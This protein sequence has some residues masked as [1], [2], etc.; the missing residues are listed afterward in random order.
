MLLRYGSNRIEQPSPDDVAQHLGKMQ[1]LDTLVLE[2]SPETFLQVLYAQDSY[3]IEYRQS[4]AKN[5]MK[6]SKPANQ[7]EVLRVFGDFMEQ[8]QDGPPQ[9]PPGTTW[10]DSSTAAPNKFKALQNYVTR[11]II[12]ADLRAEDRMLQGGNTPSL[13]IID[14]TKAGLFGR[15]WLLLIQAMLVVILIGTFIALTYLLIT[16]YGT[17]PIGWFIVILLIDIWAFFAFITVQ[18]ALRWMIRHLFAR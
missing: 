4:A 13:R 15:L 1:N 3:L 8:M 18:P 11:V 16:D 12:R 7:A 14:Y 10:E 17:T 2:K 9:L 6:A 5:L